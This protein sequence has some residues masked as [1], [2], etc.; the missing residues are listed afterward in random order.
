MNV[1]VAVSRLV[2]DIV[3]GED[4]SLEFS[5][6]REAIGKRTRVVLRHK[7]SRH[8]AYSPYSPTPFGYAREGQALVPCSEAET[9]HLIQ[10]WHAERQS[11][12]A[13]AAELNSRGIATKNGKTWYASTV[14]AILANPL[15]RE[16]AA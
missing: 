15:H 9:V 7:R 11:L 12:R 13:I 14:R 3:R 2:H 1:S 5:P 8:Q 4:P 6:Q 10:Q 16:V